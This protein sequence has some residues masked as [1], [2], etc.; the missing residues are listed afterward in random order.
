MALFRLPGGH[1]GEETPV[2]IPNTVVKLS[3][4]HG[5][6]RVTLWESRSLPGNF[7]YEKE[8]IIYMI[9]SFFYGA[10]RC[11]VFCGDILK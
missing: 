9:L 11:L 2:P 1:S 3:S 7:F 10:K 8:R 5:T 4:A 6:A